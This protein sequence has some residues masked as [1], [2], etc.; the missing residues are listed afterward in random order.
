M[1]RG[2]V[3]REPR[4]RGHLFARVLVLLLAGG[5]AGAAQKDEGDLTVVGASQLSC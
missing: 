1:M 2:L 5:L 3:A 4:L